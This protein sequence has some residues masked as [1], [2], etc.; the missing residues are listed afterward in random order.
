MQLAT[1]S[2]F[3]A[4]PLKQQPLSRPPG[5]SFPCHQRPAFVLRSHSKG[6]EPQMGQALCPCYGVLIDMTHTKKRLLR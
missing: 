1:T 2:E 3:L 5:I 6:E 4:F